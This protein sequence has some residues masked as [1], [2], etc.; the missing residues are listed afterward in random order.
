MLSHD[1]NFDREDEEIRLEDILDDLEDTEDPLEEAPAD[2]VQVLGDPERSASVWSTESDQKKEITT[3]HDLKEDEEER[4]QNLSQK[5]FASK[6]KNVFSNC[7]ALN[8]YLK[9][10][11]RTMFNFYVG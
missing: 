6:T 4:R 11:L 3:D 9:E 7:F 8:F 1:F 5:I 2:F 10:A